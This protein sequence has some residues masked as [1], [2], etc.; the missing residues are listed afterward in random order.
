VSNAQ[1]KGPCT[2]QFTNVLAP[3]PLN[4]TAR[5]VAPH[6]HAPRAAFSKSTEHGAKI[7]RGG[8]G[9]K[10]TQVR[11][12]KFGV[13]AGAKCDCKES[14]SGGRFDHI[15]LIGER[16]EPKGKV[17]A[18]GT[19]NIVKCAKSLRLLACASRMAGVKFH[20]LTLCPGS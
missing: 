19:S 3:A 7:T 12:V 13:P 15:G 5:R 1:A 18:Y 16:S 17:V 20:W 6:A 11:P 14:G 9:A 10:I 4:P 2:S 8:H